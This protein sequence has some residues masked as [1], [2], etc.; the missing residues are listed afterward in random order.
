MYVCAWNVHVPTAGIGEEKKRI[1]F[2]S[3]S[4]P[5]GRFF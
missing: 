5:V 2:A 1:E 4:G 3:W